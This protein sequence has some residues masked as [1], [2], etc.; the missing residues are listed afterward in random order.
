MPGIFIMAVCRS[1]SKYNS[2]LHYLTMPFQLHRLHS[3]Q[4]KDVVSDELTIM[5]KEV[6]VA[7][8]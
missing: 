7:C 4:Q 6:I 8:L 3:T 2:F 5:W 1:H